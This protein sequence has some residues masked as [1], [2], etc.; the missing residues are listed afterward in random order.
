MADMKTELILRPMACR[1]FSAGGV[2]VNGLKFARFKAWL[3]ALMIA[4]PMASAMLMLNRE[5]RLVPLEGIEGR[6]SQ[7]EQKGTRTLARAAASL[8]DRGFYRYERSDNA[9]EMPIWCDRHGP[10]RRSENAY[11]AYMATLAA[12]AFFGALYSKCPDV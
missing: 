12:F 8:R 9:G 7:C 4:S 11:K 5:V 3:L 10:D 2:L 1:V 6:C